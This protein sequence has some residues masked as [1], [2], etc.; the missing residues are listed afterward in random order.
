MLLG[1]NVTL[2]YHYFY[3]QLV[4]YGNRDIIIIIPNKMYIVAVN[5]I[6]MLVN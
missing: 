2:T 6:L 5:I 1:E 4:N 3:K